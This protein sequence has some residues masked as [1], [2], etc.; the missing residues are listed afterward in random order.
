MPYLDSRQKEYHSSTY[1]QHDMTFA[2]AMLLYDTH[3][4]DYNRID[5]INVWRAQTER[6]MNDP[7]E[8]DV[9]LGEMPTFRFNHESDLIG[10]SGY[11]PLHSFFMCKVLPD[12]KDYMKR[13]NREMRLINHTIYTAQILKKDVDSIL[14]CPIG[15]VDPSYYLW[16]GMS[17]D[18]Q[19]VSRVHYSNLESG[20]I[21]NGAGLSKFFDRIAHE[22]PSISP[23]KLYSFRQPY[24]R[25]GH[26]SFRVITDQRLVDEIMRIKAFDTD[27]DQKRKM[28]NDTGICKEYD[29]YLDLIKRMDDCRAYYYSSDR[30]KD[31]DD[32]LYVLGQILYSDLDIMEIAEKK[33]D[34]DAVYAAIK[35]IPYQK[36]DNY[37]NRSIEDKNIIAE[38]YGSE[39]YVPYFDIHKD[40]KTQRTLLKD[41]VLEEYGL[42]L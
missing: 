8:G 38:I 16:L 34:L 2:E 15:D 33:D 10:V 35:G 40:H 1:K 32:T 13:L 23:E 3:V 31:K 26:Y 12:I 7:Q 39:F 41:P 6:V 42:P 24:P 21:K 27:D 18:G 28:I 25:G 11:S 30:A 19:F 22:V 29:L 4:E 17:A 14:V 5:A 9:H 36:Y 37:M 20:T